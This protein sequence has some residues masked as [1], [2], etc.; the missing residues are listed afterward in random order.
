M[1]VFAVNSVILISPLAVIT[2]TTW[3]TL[4]RRKSK[5][6]VTLIGAGEDVAMKR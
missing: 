2:V 6:I 3:I 5:Q 1:A 4:V